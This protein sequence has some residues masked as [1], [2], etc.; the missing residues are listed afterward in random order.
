MPEVIEIS[1][2]EKFKQ[3]YDRIKENLEND[4][5][6]FASTMLHPTIARFN[7]VVAIQQHYTCTDHLDMEDNSYLIKYRKPIKEIIKDRLQK[8]LI[9]LADGIDKTIEFRKQKGTYKGEFTTSV[10]LANAFN[11]LLREDFGTIFHGKE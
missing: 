2:V 11:D 7:E 9:W 5:G 3:R 10:I 1:L 6:G 8:R 4:Q